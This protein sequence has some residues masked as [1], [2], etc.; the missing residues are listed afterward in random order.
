M[1]DSEEELDGSHISSENSQEMK[2]NGEAKFH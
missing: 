2:W 1:A